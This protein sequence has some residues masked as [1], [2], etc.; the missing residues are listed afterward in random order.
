ME[1]ALANS[2]HRDKMCNQIET[3]FFMLIFKYFINNR[4]LELKSNED[5]VIMC[6][7]ISFVLI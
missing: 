5:N 3:R 2:K 6:E 4:I 7:C 1:P